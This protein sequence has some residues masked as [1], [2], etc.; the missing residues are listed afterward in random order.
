[1]SACACVCVR[2]C[3]PNRERER[4]KNVH[5]RVKD[6]ESIGG[7]MSICAA[8]YLDSNCQIFSLL[9]LGLQ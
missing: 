2:V 1:V 8:A 7:L 3:V 5:V 6:R 4:E 9:Q